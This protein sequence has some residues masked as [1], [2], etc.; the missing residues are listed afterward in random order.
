MVV[1]RNQLNSHNICQIAPAM[2]P[3]LVGQPFRP[4]AS[5]HSNPTTGGEFQVCF[6]PAA[7]LE[8]AAEVLWAA[9]ASFAAALLAG[10]ALAGAAAGRFAA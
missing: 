2:N 3:G 4:A 8:G 6:V 10:A 7:G 9:A 5:R 1:H